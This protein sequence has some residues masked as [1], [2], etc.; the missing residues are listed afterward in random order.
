MTSLKKAR[1]LGT[2]NG[3]FHADEVTACALLLYFDIID[4]DKIYRTREPSI[5][6]SC[7]FICDVGGIYDP[8]KKLFDHHQASYQGTLSS[9]GMILLFLKEQ[10][11]ISEAIFN[12]L[13]DNLIK[14]VDAHDIGLTQPR[15]GHAEFSLIVS[16]FVPVSYTFTEQEEKDAFNQAL[17]FVLGHLD[18][19]I[20]RHEF[21]SSCRPK[22]EKAMQEASDC[23]VFH[24]ALPWIESFFELGGEEHPAKFIIMPVG[25]LWKLRGIPPNLKNR[26]QVRQLLP[27]KWA[28][29]LENE[30][31]EISGIEGGVFCHKERFISM[32]KNLDSAK[33]ALHYVLKKSIEE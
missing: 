7:E 15:E 9:A 18:R 24:E 11:V 20:K 1:S 28:G 13:N 23:L 12:L 27:E 5:L 4:R 3:R 29:L 32:W 16:N 8:D 19:M 26:M 30:L 2:H 21:V 25:D 17:D 31:A 14:G 22:V 33:Q 6:E 10:S